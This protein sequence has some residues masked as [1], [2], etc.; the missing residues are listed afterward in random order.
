MGK[1]ADILRLLKGY[2]SAVANGQANLDLKEEEVEASSRAKA[3][4][5]G[6]VAKLHAA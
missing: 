2:W 1:L 3:N 4:T 5:K 6:H